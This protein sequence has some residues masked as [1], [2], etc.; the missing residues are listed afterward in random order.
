MRPARQSNST[1]IRTEVLWYDLTKKK[2]VVP[3]HLHVMLNLKY[4]LLFI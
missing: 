1:I 4:Y 3:Y 2:I